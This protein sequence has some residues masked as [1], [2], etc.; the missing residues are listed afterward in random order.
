MPEIWDYSRY[1]EFK[2]PGLFTITNKTTGS[3]LDLAG[4]GAQAGTAIIG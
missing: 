3:V 1:G 2:T 4:G